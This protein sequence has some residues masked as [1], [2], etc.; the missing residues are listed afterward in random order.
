MLH[1]IVTTRPLR[2]V[3]TERAFNPANRLHLLLSIEK[4]TSSISANMRDYLR[5]AAMAELPVRPHEP[6][7]PSFCVTADLLI[8][9]RGQPIHNACIIVKGSK[10]THVGPRSD[11]AA[12]YSHLPTTHVKV[13]MPGMWDCHTHF[14]GEAEVSLEHLAVLKPALAGFRAVRDCVAVLNAGFTSVREVGGYG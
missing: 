12:H 1:K 3:I 5:S 2:N 4:A 8:P 13:L 9:G 7:E 10:I 6:E 14:F 11:V